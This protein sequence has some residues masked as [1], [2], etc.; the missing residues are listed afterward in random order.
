[1]DE[2]FESRRN[3]EDLM[4]ILQQ[5]MKEHPNDS[6]QDYAKE[7]FDKLDVLYMTW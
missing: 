3:I 6:K 4:L 7:L 5:W 2:L 1:M